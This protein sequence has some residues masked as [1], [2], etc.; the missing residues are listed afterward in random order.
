MDK[1]SVESL[2]QRYSDLVRKYFPVR[3]VFLYGSYAKGNAHHDSDIDIAVIVDKIDGDYLEQQ[4]RLFRLR[5][6]IDLRIEPVLLEGDLD[7][8]GFLQEIMTTGQI[9]YSRTAQ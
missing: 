4:S 3:Q 1:E 7:K 9:I 2:V 8:T 5:R 6:T